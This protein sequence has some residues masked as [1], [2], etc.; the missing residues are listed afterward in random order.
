[1]EG[2]RF[3]IDLVAAAAQEGLD[4]IYTFVFAPQD[5]SHV[6]E[7]V[8]VFERVGG[9]VVFV[10]LVAPREELLRR[11]GDRGRRAHRKITDA[12]TLEHVLDTHDVYASVPERESLTVDVTR[13]RR[14]KPRSE[15]SRT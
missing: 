3:R 2:R 9:T 13:H 12:A 7:V 5:E 4:L 14:K 8:E 6:D 1:M 10:R 11:V 15:F